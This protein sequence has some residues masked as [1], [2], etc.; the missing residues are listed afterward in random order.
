MTFEYRIPTRTHAHV[1]VDRFII[2]I[3]NLEEQQVSDKRTEKEEKERQKDRKR[4][5]KKGSK[6]ER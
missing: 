2:S 4:K 5:R 6:R 3:P 1:F